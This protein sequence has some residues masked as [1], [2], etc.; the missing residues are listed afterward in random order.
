MH[1]TGRGTPRNPRNPRNSPCLLALLLL[2]ACSRP[3]T[4]LDT[5]VF[6]ISVDTLRSDRVTPALTP[7]ILA[8]ARDGVTF[9]RAFSHIPQTLPSHA[10]MLTGLV[11]SRA[12]VRDNIGY[13]VPETVAWLP[14]LLQANGY[15]T[16]AAVSSYVLRRSTGM[17]RGFEFYDDA[18]EGEALDVTAERGGERTSAALLQWLQTQTS[19]KLFAFL[20]LYEPHAP[21]PR[22][23]DTD[24]TA[25]DKVVGE[26]VEA[27]KQRGLYDD[28][29]IVFVSD[30]GEGLGDHGEPDHGVFLYREAIQ[31]PLIVKLPRRERAGERVQSLAALSDVAPTILAHAGIDAPPNLDGVALLRTAVPADRQVDAESFYPRLHF[32]WAELTSV[33]TSQHQYIQAPRAEL[34]DWIADPAERRNLIADERRV[35]HAL[36]SALAKRVRPPAPPSQVDAEDQRKLAALGYVG[37]S[38]PATADFPDPKDRIE[39]LA[40]YRRAEGLAR[41]GKTADAVPLLRKITVNAP[42]IVD[43]WLLLARARPDEAVAILRE[44]HRHFPGSAAVVLP[45]ADAYLRGGRHAEARAHAELALKSDPVIAHEMLAKIALAAR[46]VPSARKHAEAALAV[47]PE[48]MATLLM[49]ARIEREQENWAGVL[50]ALDRIRGSMRG[51]QAD[52]GEALLHLGRGPEAEQ[53]FRAEVQAYPDNVTAWG[54]LAVVLAAQRRFDEAR[55]TVDDALRHNPGATKMAAEVRALIRASESR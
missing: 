13:A 25:A 35:A 12:G 15:Q 11:P 45:L 36:S 50:A 5:P 14:S 37:S 41:E 53:A 52:R 31:V 30:H 51:V 9:E 29:L 27:L 2:A 40:M 32:G 24:V 54:N 46:D 18:L 19:R 39:F 34:Y 20:H 26:F 42:G 17:A 10:T 22:G 48:R 44:A 8:L 38:A 3:E 33:V 49:V 7:N 28:A 47:A 16:G 55:R 43:A 1:S 4:R 21:Y 6:L 23:Y